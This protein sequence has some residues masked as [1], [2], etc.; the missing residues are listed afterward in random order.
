LS[1]LAG[2]NTRLAFRIGTDNGFGDFGWFLDDIRIYTCG[3]PSDLIFANGFDAGNLT[4]WSGTNGGADLVANGVS[5]MVGTPFG[6]QGTV[7]DT[8]GLYVQDN[9]PND[10]PRYR[11]RFYLDPNT[12]DPGEAG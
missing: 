10:E 1:S 7:N 8:V 9:T 2:Q 6:M 11:A 4:A 12:F 5:G 3:T